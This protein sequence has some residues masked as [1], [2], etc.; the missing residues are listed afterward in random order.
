MRCLIIDDHP[1]TRRGLANLLERQF[2]GIAISEATTVAEAVQAITSSEPIIAILEL[3]LTGHSGLSALRSLRAALARDAVSFLVF[4]RVSDAKTIGLCSK[5]GARG[6]VSKSEPEEVLAQAFRTIAEGGSYFRQ[7]DAM[8][9]WYDVGGL[10][11]LTRRQKE[12][13]DLVLVGYSN[14]Q[15]AAA[16]EISYGTVKNYMFNLMR[17]AGVNS[18]L[19]L[20]VKFRKP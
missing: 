4:S 14:K 7:G 1:V 11:R 13:L 20:A 5:C 6:Y 10:G 15:I 2:P 3:D 17:I 16:L 18:R 19:E 8:Q 9:R 12:I